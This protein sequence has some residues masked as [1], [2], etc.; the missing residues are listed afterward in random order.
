ML[1]LDEKGSR[2][3]RHTTV[4]GDCL[5]RPKEERFERL[6]PNA[7]FSLESTGKYSSRVAKLRSRQS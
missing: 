2:Q 7:F 5:W 6:R 1:R 4:N 3:R